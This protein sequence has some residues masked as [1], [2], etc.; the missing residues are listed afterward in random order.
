MS[1]NTLFNSS[2]ILLILILPCVLSSFDKNSLLISDLTGVIDAEFVPDLAQIVVLSESS[3]RVVNSNT[4]KLTDIKLAA[5][6]G[7]KFVSMAVGKNAESTMVAVNSQNGKITIFDLVGK[8]VVLSDA[9][10]TAPA[11]SMCFSEIGNTSMLVTTY[12]D[13]VRVFNADTDISQVILTD[14]D[15]LVRAACN[16][17][18]GYIFAVSWVRNSSFVS[19]FD[20]SVDFDKLTILK[21]ITLNELE[22]D[23]TDLLFNPRD[24]T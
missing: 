4:G 7:E 12:N 6:K 19:L 16:P 18:N 21:T 8:E 5:G 20:I 23:V 22:D 13:Q 24:T 1:T 3:L 17:S 2:A 9:K 10:M 15:S 11:T 14:E